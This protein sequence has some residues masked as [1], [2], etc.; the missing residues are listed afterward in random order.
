VEIHYKRGEWEHADEDD[1]EDTEALV[2]LR[3]DLI[4]TWDLTGDEESFF[5]FWFRCSECDYQLA[6]E[7]GRLVGDDVELAQ[8]IIMSGNKSQ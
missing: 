3:P 5:H 6:Y 1:V 4:G 8:W 7:G 2:Q